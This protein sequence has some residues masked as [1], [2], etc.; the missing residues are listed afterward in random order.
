MYIKHVV[1][2]G[3]MYW[4]WS[5]S[6]HPLWSCWV[7]LSLSSGHGHHCPLCIIVVVVHCGH[8]WW[9]IVICGGGPC[10]VVVCHCPWS[11]PWS[12]VV[13]VF[14]SCSSIVVAWLSLVLV[15]HWSLAV[16]SPPA[17]I[18]APLVLFLLCPQNHAAKCLC[19][20]RTLKPCH[21]N[22]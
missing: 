15:V 14:A 16:V 7:G 8:G 19:N 21:V 4:L 5:M 10:I 2:H 3:G 6:C 12:S 17:D 18:G 20:L 22:I 13:M 9:C 1:H 11:W